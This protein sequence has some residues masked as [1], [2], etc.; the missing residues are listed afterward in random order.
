MDEDQ[1]WQIISSLF[2]VPDAQ[3]IVKFSF[4]RDIVETAINKQVTLDYFSRSSEFYQKLKE[5]GEKLREFPKEPKEIRR[6]ILRSF[7]MSY[8]VMINVLREEI[9]NNKFIANTYWSW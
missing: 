3:M 6:N 2:T 8:N 1:Q 7:M 4:I 5:M 9:K